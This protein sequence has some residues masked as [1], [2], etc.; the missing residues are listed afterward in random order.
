MTVWSN[1]S[2][3]QLRSRCPEG[4]VTQNNSC[5]PG[6]GAEPQ[7]AENAQLRRGGSARFSHMALHRH[8]LPILYQIWLNWL[9]RL[10]CYTDFSKKPHCTNNFGQKSRYNILP[11]QGKGTRGF[12]KVVI[13]RC[14]SWLVF[15]PGNWW[16]RDAFRYFHEIHILS[17]G[18]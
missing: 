5:S 11:F 12:A 18:E 2:N 17:L 3:S 8:C 15:M 7:Q 10:L 14:I 9:S 4:R 16:Y 1:D 6:F 13:T